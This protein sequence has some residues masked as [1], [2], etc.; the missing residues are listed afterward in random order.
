MTGK[1]QRK[2]PRKRAKAM[3]PE[4]KRL[5]ANRALAEPEKRREQLA[6]ELIKAIKE[7][8]P[9]EIPPAPETVIKKISE[10]RSVW[11]FDEDKPWR[12]STLP[13]Y[14]IQP[15]SLP[16]VL[17]IYMDMTKQG[18]CLTIRE[19]RWIGR[20]AFVVK[21]SKM[22]YNHA[23]QRAEAERFL[24]AEGYEFTDISDDIALYS[25]ITGESFSAVEMDKIRSGQL[26]ALQRQA[27]IWE[28]FSKKPK[29]EAKNE[30]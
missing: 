14:E 15:Q 27:D 3:L 5:I 29:K 9:K 19:A 2:E 12:I 26:E 17:Q 11:L 30:R 1:E 23:L 20:L 24:M 25:E 7:R 6:E 13:D 4:I 8:F 18:I 16:R 21:D 10:A 28:S 22:L